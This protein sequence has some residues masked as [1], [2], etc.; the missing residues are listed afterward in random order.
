MEVRFLVPESLVS[1]LNCAKS[2]F[3]NAGFPFLAESD[4]A[5]DSITETESTEC[6]IQ[7]VKKVPGSP[8]IS[9]CALFD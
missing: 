4:A 2:L 1:I 9:N 7:G 8:A 3:G 6:I 5:M